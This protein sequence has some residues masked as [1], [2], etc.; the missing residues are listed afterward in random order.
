MIMVPYLSQVL[1]AL[2]ETFPEEEPTTTFLPPRKVGIW[3]GRTG[4][5]LGLIKSN[6]CKVAAND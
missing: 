6:Y 2:F 1:F 5:A 4:I 3:R